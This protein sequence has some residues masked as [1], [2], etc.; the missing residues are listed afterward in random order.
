MHT[1]FWWAIILE[2]EHLVSQK[3]DA[4]TALR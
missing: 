4:Q 2:N 1:K 3:G